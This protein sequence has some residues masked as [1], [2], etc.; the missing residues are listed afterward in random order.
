M[1]AW[2]AEALTACDERKADTDDLHI[3][4]ESRCIALTAG[5][6]Y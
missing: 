6:G 2:C 3:H 5:A 1:H 4:E